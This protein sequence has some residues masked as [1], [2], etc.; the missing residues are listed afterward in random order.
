MSTAE[1][2]YECFTLTFFLSPFIIRSVHYKTGVRG[3]AVG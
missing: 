1:M 2:K 3:G